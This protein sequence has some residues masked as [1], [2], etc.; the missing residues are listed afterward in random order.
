MAKIQRSVSSTPRGADGG[1][2]DEA[3]GSASQPQHSGGR[4][5]VG[6]VSGELFSPSAVARAGGL[7]A[8]SSS[9]VGVGGG[10]GGGGG[11]E[12]EDDFWSRMQ[13][14]EVA[15]AG[16]LPSEVTRRAAPWGGGPS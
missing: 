1:L 10:G 12:S 5:G 16:A 4:G 15:E 3:A 14:E 7:D 13:E 2:S 11:G 8:A 6:D 9:G